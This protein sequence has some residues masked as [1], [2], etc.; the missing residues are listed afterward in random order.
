MSLQGDQVVLDVSEVIDQV[1]QRLVDRGLTMVENLPIP[2]ADRQ[3]VLFDAP[4][5]QQARTTYAVVNPVAQWLHRDR[6]GALPR[7]RSCCPGA[8]RG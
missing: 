5:L 7:A 3:I 4:Q 6:R 1:K 2:D 8:G